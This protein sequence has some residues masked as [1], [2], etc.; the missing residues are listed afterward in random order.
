MPIRIASG[1][2]G[3]ALAVILI[4][5]ALRVIRRIE[6]AAAAAGISEGAR[7]A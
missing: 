1:F 2:A 7:A 6:E 5:A 3:V 4:S